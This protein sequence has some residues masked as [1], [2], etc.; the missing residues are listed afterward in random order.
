[1]QYEIQQ[2]FITLLTLVFFHSTRLFIFNIQHHLNTLPP[3]ISMSTTLTYPDNV[4]AQLLEYWFRVV[5][6]ELLYQDILNDLH[7]LKD[8][9]ITC[10]LL[11]PVVRKRIEK[12]FWFGAN[13]RFSHYVPTKQFNVANLKD[14]LPTTKKMILD[15]E[16]DQ[17]IM[18]L[19]PQINHF[20]SGSRFNNLI[21]LRNSNIIK[22]KFAFDFNQLIDKL[23]L[24]LQR[25]ELGK[26]Y[27]Q[28]LQN[29][30]NTL[31]H[32]IFSEG[33]IFNMPIE[34]GV[35]PQSLVFL[36]MSASFDYPISGVLPTNL[37]TLKLGLNFNS[38]IYELPPQLTYLELPF[39]YN[40]IL[41]HAR[42]LPKNLKIV[43]S[44]KRFV[45]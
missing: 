26:L 31:T 32:L 4:G 25:L 7:L 10:K 20:T 14:I 15:D 36:S 44:H 17:P 16:F 40:K 12:K 39:R 19:P 29:L 37:R 24:K 9:T 28:P 34:R 22:M 1:M 5:M 11:S 45:Y 41:P 27:N 3:S 13:K 35:L 21:D 2:P 18:S 23:P 42:S 30:P 6:N 38:R 8:L 43:R 33:S